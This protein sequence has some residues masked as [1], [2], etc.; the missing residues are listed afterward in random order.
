MTDRRW[1]VACHKGFHKDD[2]QQVSV[3][4]RGELPGVYE[5]PCAVMLTLSSKNEL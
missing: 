2:T 5:S 3:N 4:W 1:W